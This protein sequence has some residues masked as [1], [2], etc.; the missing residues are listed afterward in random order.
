LAGGFTAP[1]APMILSPTS[2]S[3]TT[4]PT[5]TI[6]GRTEPTSLVIISIDGVEVGRVNSDSGGIFEFTPPNPL[7]LGTHTITAV[8]EIDGIRSA[9][10]DPVIYTYA[11]VVDT[12]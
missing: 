12:D 2:G 7:A 9:N 3:T 5:P 11:P 10:S 1:N 4:D 8:V 6:R